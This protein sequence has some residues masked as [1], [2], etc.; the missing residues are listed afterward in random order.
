MIPKT[1]VPIF[2]K[3]SNTKSY[4]EVLAECGRFRTWVGENQPRKPAPGML[5]FIRGA[6]IEMVS[7]TY[8]SK[9]RVRHTPAAACRTG[10][11][12]HSSCDQS[13]V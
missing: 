13:D 7:M 3:F 5:K 6:A 1:W 10:G 2:K 12:S 4:K 9:R 11:A 8:I